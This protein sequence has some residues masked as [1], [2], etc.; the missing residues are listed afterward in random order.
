MPKIILGLV[1][2]QGCGK[3]TIADVLQKD[4]QAGYYRFSSILSDILNR[5][6]IE[7]SRTNLIRISTVLRQSFGEDVLSYALE[8]H[9]LQAPEDIVIIDGIRRPE[10][11]VALEPLPQFKLI[12]VDADPR[13]RFERMKGRGEKVGESNMS[14][15]QFLADEQAPTEITIP[16]VMERATIKIE[17]NGTQNELIAKVHEMMTGLGFK[18]K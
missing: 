16:L 13:L 15:E 11:I 7:K 17:N 10:D 1:G 4:Y 12:S 5:L 2:K 8:S 9:V 14:W 18:Q 3:G 6:G